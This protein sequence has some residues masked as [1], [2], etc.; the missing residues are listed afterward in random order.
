M[1]KW[2][3]DKYQ[4]ASWEREKKFNILTHKLENANSFVENL[5]IQMYERWYYSKRLIS[6]IDD[7]GKFYELWDEYFETVTN[8]NRTLPYNKIKV[9][10]LAG[11]EVASMLDV[12][13]EDEKRADIPKSIAARFADLHNKGLLGL[14]RWVKYDSIAL[15]KAAIDSI[16]KSSDT[17][18]DSIDRFIDSLDQR[19]DELEESQLNP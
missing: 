1:G 2:I 15:K 19:I 18:N 5:S 14:R 6:N 13:S 16:S 10:R 4:T 12:L 9:K 17:L 3:N 8:W 7:K 11:E